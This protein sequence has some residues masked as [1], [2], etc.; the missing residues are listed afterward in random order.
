MPKQS[1]T[2]QTRRKA[3]TKLLCRKATALVADYLNDELDGPTRSAFEAHLKECG[4]CR[5]FL[6]TYKKTAR[7]VQSLRYEELPPDLQNRVLLLIR[8]R[9]KKGP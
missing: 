7:T 2:R 9:L 1:Q 4:N 3:P 8:Q 6:S 5:A